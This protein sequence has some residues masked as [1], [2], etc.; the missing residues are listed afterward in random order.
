MNT[1]NK[2]CVYTALNT[3]EKKMVTVLADLRDNHGA[4]AVKA[5]FETEGTRLNE[6][7][8]LKD[9][10]AQCNMGIMM[11]IGGPEAVRDI[12]DA[13]LVG[14]YGIVAP[15]VESEYALKKYLLAIE[16][17]V[18]GDVRQDLLVGVNIETKHACQQFPE[19]LKTPKIE[20]LN[21]ATVG[22]VDLSGSM[23]LNRDE[24]N[25][26]AVF[27]LT[28]GVYEHARVAGIKTTMGGGIS[29]QAAPFINRL[30]DDSLLDKFETRKV[31][32][33]AS[34]GMQNIEVGL[35]KANQFELLWLQNKADYYTTISREDLQ[36]IGMLQSRSTV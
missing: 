24:I 17:F 22:R 29:A 13:L 6:L 9:I 19:M 11:K 14:V 21:F 5:E 26:D 30:M 2:T 1:P 36:R 31:V 18:P 32:F 34:A 12:Q 7:M 23:G 25:S 3:I 10:V 33:S 15:M 27:D 16:K 20:F 8:R 35:A 28:K 4:I